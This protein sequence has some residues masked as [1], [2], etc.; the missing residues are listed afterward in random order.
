ML[1][2]LSLELYFFSRSLLFCGISPIV[3]SIHILYEQH[4]FCIPYINMYLFLICSVWRLN[5]QIFSVLSQAHPVFRGPNK[6][7]THCPASCSSLHSVQTTLVL[8]DCSIRQS[9][10]LPHTHTVGVGSSTGSLPWD[11]HALHAPLISCITTSC[12]EHC[13]DNADLHFLKFNGKKCIK[14]TTITANIDR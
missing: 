3:Y 7:I 1:L 4:V 12:P 11:P 2:F 6:A 10:D 8:P 14:V 9:Q 5:T 13:V